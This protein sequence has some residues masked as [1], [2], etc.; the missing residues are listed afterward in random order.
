MLVVAVGRRARTV[1]VQSSWFCSKRR[2]KLI[3]LL[4]APVPPKPDFVWLWW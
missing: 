3:V 1:K 2:R 4:L